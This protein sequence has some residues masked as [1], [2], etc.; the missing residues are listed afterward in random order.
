MIESW[1]WVQVV[2][3]IMYL[4]L[5]FLLLLYLLCSHGTSRWINLIYFMTKCIARKRSKTDFSGALEKHNVME[6]YAQNICNIISQINLQIPSQNNS[7][8]A[9]H[10]LIWRSL[11]QISK[12]P[13]KYSTRQGWI[14]AVILCT[15]LSTLLLSTLW[16]SSVICASGLNLLPFFFIIQA[17]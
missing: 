11:T 14:F 15:Q 5:H 7:P 4:T 12:Q 17:I 13:H 16:R 3:R 1:Q 9:S 8:E 10:I 6:I 2:C